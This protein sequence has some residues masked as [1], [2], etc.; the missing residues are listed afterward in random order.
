[1]AKRSLLLSGLLLGSA[2]A[3]TGCVAAAIP[4]VAGGAMVVRGDSSDD[5][6]VEQAPAPAVAKVDSPV[7]SSVPAPS[8]LTVA[9]T[10]VELPPVAGPSDRAGAL[11]DDPG[12]EP[13]DGND[14]F[15]G[16]FPVEGEA[17]AASELSPLTAPARVATAPGPREPL[18]LRA[19]DA[20]YSYVDAQAR[21]DPV[22]QPRDSALLASPAL[23]RPDRTECSIR[24]PAVVV[25]IDP[26]EGIFDPS[27][28]PAPNTM[29]GQ[30]LGAMRQQ[31]IEIYW[32][33]AL[34]AVQAG[35]V[36]KALG[37]AGLDPD[38]KDQ[39]LLM[40]N[41]ED[42]KQERRRELARSHCV[43]AIAGD[44]RADFDELFAYLKDRSAAQPLEELVGAGWFL[45]PL[46]L[47]QGL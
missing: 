25:D 2:V 47:E 8:A 32:I 15:E 21:R 44:T 22:E 42:R 17:V 26:G 46:P 38:G 33:S 23:L 12:E 20:L 34:P 16:A 6:K 13:A 27:I 1:M 24:P 41:G 28:T 19:Y 4:I 29:L 11:E 9:T 5:E 45:T 18:S 43:V 3:L 31:E 37:T 35:A 40:R 30:M 10:P 7:E 39:L 14:S 36:R